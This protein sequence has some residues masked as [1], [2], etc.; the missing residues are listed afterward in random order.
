MLIPF[1]S[2]PAEGCRQALA[3][4]QLPRLERLLARLDAGPRDAGDERSLSMPHERVLARAC[5]LA[6]ADGRI[7]WAAWQLQQAG[8]SP[9]RQA[10]ARITPCHWRVGSDHVAMEDPDRLEL[11]EDESRALLAAVQPFFDE[12]GMAL[13]YAAPTCWL[14]R[15][16]IFRDLPAASL[17]RVIGRTVDAWLPRV[18][19]AGP[20]RRLQQEV[21][22][23]LYTHAVNDDRQQRGLPPVNSFWVSGTGALGEAPPAP[24]AA[25]PQPVPALR[26]PALAG[27]WGAWA[28]AWREL[29][30][31]PC[32]RL[33]AAASAGQAVTLTLCGERHAQSWTG[34]GSGGLRRW[35]AGR[36]AGRRAAAALEAL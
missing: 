20:L 22:M 32:A 9:G 23:L 10:W 26:E 34:G 30:A 5:G 33:L 27:D 7:P 28:D 11:E 8:R 1:A 31:G 21:Q 12:D 16:E 35:L 4:L 2:S 24:L 6:V 13:E 3:S 17:D 14:A 25:A 29:D 19:G 36:F 15:G 18:A